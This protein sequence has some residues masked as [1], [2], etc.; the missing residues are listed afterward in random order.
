[1]TPETPSSDLSDL[2]TLTETPG[3]DH[4]NDDAN[5]ARLDIDTA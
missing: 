2:P 1:M 5:M 3:P 4:G